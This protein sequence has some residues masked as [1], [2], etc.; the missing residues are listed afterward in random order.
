MNEYWLLNTPHF[1]G[2]INFIPCHKLLYAEPINYMHIYFSIVKIFVSNVQ[3]STYLAQ[4][5][6]CTIQYGSE[7]RAS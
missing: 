3:R 2:P 6:A 4:F 1:Y 5:L 7:S